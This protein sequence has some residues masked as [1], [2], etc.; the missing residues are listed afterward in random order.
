[1]NAARAT[2]VRFD[3]ATAV[4][5]VVIE[6]GVLARYVAAAARAYRSDARLPQCIGILLGRLSH[7]AAVV[8]E[9][10]LA[11]NARGSDQSA[12]LEFEQIAIRFGDAY[13]DEDRGY[14]CDP[15]SVLAIS[16]RASASGRE[17]LG[18]IHLHPDGGRIGLPPERA[19]LLSADPTD[20]D[21]YVFQQTGWPVSMIIYLEA[22]DGRL[23]H[24]ISAWAPIEDEQGARC[25]R[26]P[27]RLRTG[28]AESVRASAP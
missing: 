16:R 15:E 8:E 9:I 20:M 21:L 22:I 11:R 26:L 27:V 24:E 6:R 25:L 17:V 10:R 19:W 28:P 14:W 13:R 18:S 2:S 7:R 5:P 23:A 4:R 12:R 1:M 3:G